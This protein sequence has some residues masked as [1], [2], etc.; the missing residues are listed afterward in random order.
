MKNKLNKGG[1]LSHINFKSL[2]MISFLV[3]IWIFFTITTEGLFFS[4]RNL[5]L[6]LKQ[7]TILT[8]LGIGAV[9]VIITRNFDISVG[10][11]TALN[12]MIA[13]VLII[14]HN[15]A[16]LPA[17]IVVFMA[18]IV[19]GIW[20]GF[21]VSKIK[22]PSFIVTLGGLMLFRGVVLLISGGETV[23][24]MPDNFLKIETAFVPPYIT[25]ILILLVFI[26]AVI[27]VFIDKR[28]KLKYGIFVTS[29][30]VILKIF[31]FLVICG[32]LFYITF[33]YKGLPYP[34]LILAILIFIFNFIM[35]KTKFG[36]Q[37]YATG[38]NPE[39]AELSGINTKKVVFLA[40]I[41]M[42]V[43]VSIAGILYL[44][45]LSAA[46]SNGGAGLELEAIAAA[47][48]GGTS[49]SGGVGTVPGVL[50][51]G[52]VMSSIDN[53]MSLMNISPF[54]QYI[55]KGLVLTAAVA[56]DVSIKNR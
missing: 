6:L 5:T 34:V 47:V 43:L 30:M 51:G 48:I 42:S 15:W 16:I 23:G 14:K 40:F 20:N 27:F 35:T 37:I 45:R 4:P 56:Y 21:L 1:I 8:T 29:K 2:V 49:I 36:R 55:A 46:P 11:V 9:I 24:A 10:S 22:I 19:T 32:L 39:A 12:A 31:T 13:A 3:C 25:A 28:S 41:I 26:I 44:A 7:T 33:Y 18:S 17:L 54:I 53:G 38:G 52:L 50:I